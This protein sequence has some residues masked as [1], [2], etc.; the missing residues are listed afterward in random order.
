MKTA[1][2]LE[3]AG[4]TRDSS[5]TRH[6]ARVRIEELVLHGFAPADR[7]RIADAVERELARLMSPGLPE[8]REN[9]PALDRINAGA[10]SVK[11][12]TKPQ[13]AGTE[14]ARAVFR[15]LRQSYRAAYGLQG[16]SVKGGRR[17]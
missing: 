15:S 7:H 12:G 2:Q 17:S 6:S 9:P 11:A 10:F 4:R 5:V 14:I 3:R 8:F 16:Q 1:A 13:A